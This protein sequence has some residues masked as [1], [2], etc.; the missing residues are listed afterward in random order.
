L[1]ALTSGLEIPETFR[2]SAKSWSALTGH[3]F[4]T[5]SLRNAM[6]RTINLD[7]TLEYGLVV[8]YYDSRGKMFSWIWAH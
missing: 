7:K 5:T 6:L 3:D 1:P 4:G 8:G 2:I